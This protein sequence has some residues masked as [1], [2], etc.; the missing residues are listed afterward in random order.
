MGGGLRHHSP[1]HDRDR[2]HYAG[3]VACRCEVRPPDAAFFLSD[4]SDTVVKWSELLTRPL[5]FKAQALHKFNEE[6]EFAPLKV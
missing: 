5:D 4:V 3:T 1:R 6:A 2:S